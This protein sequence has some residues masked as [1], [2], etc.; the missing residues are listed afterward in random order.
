MA[1]V[2]SRTA[3]APSSTPPSSTRERRRQHRLAEILEA[4]FEEFAQR[5]YAATRLEDVGQRVSLTRGAIYLYFK[6]KEELFRAVVRSVIQPVL[7]QARSVTGSFDGPSE[8]LL[9]L[10]L[11]MFYREIARDHRRSRLLRLLVADGPNFP[12]LTE[13]YYSE[14]IQH[15]I[16]CFKSAIKR[17]IDRG[18]F[19]SCPAKDFPQVIIAPVIAAVIW[20]LLFGKSHTLNLE[21]YSRA[22]FDLLMNGLKVHVS[23]AGT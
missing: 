20:S 15:G 13:F 7:Q 16:D 12:E 5:G 4:G 14:V 22:H 1:L 3:R 2:S 18:E 17:G 10:L 19:R 8:E 6:D 11:M 23:N 9:R 21:R